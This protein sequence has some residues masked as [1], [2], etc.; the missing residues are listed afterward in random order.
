LTTA[1]VIGSL[2]GLSGARGA[3]PSVN[4]L[5]APPSTPDEHPLDVALRA[6]GLARGSFAFDYADMSSFGGDRYVTPLFY[7]MQGNPLKIEPY[8]KVFRSDLMAGAA[9]V[10]GPI[11]FGGRRRHSYA[12]E[13]YFLVID[14]GGDD[15]Y[16]RAAANPGLR[17][18]ISV[19]IDEAG[20]DTYDAPYLSLGAGNAN[21]IG[22]FW[23]KVG[24]DI[25]NATA[26]LTLGRS[27]TLSRGGLRDH[28][29][30]IGL[31]L[32]TGGADRYPLAYPD[33]LDLF[34]NNTLWTRPGMIADPPL[35]TER[36][37]GYDCEWVEPE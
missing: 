16:A 19:S 13:E 31:F 14:L 4:N 9:T 15:T 2:A 10:A 17:N 29:N 37:V 22:L 21:G 27:N 20:N 7:V 6:V 30:T 35:E 25:Y 26:T 34:G 23:D 3:A 32:D 5:G 18:W 33:S 8:S 28:I 11:A 12:P 24:D 36:G 1:V